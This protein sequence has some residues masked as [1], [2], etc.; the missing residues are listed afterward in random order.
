MFL[1]KKQKGAN[2]EAEIVGCRIQKLM[3]FKGIKE[4]ELAENLKITTIELENK[5]KGKEEFYLSE[6]M[7]IKKIFHL[8]LDVF[9]E[10]FFEKDFNLEKTLTNLY[11]QLYKRREGKTSLFLKLK[12]KNRT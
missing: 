1:N 6:I 10:L 5:L 11:K 2:M 8:N 7:Q 3:E 12:E 9:T 4:K